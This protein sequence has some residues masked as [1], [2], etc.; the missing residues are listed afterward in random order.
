M[1]IKLVLSNYH[2]REIIKELEGQWL[3]PP[4]REFLVMLRDELEKSEKSSKE[5]ELNV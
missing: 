5:C 3:K 2:A 4:T 1:S